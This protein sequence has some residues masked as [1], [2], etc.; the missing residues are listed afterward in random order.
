M[1][2]HYTH[3]IL[4]SLKMSRPMWLVM[5]DDNAPTYKR[6]KLVRTY[7]NILRQKQTVADEAC[8]KT[9]SE[10]DEK[11]MEKKNYHRHVILALPLIE[12]R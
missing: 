3:K 11:Q 6:R 7:K 4:S 5:M 1:Y 2:I 9:Y 12:E 8:R 10:K